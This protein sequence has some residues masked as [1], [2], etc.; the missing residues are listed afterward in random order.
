MNFVTI[1]LLNGDH[2]TLN[3]DAVAYITEH[4]VVLNQMVGPGDYLVQLEISETTAKLLSLVVEKL[5]PAV[6]DLVTL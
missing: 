4:S 1:P 3:L 5:S 2:I 6:T